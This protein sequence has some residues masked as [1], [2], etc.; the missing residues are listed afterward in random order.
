MSSTSGCIPR[1]TLIFVVAAWITLTITM[2][3]IASMNF[4][5]LDTENLRQADEVYRAIPEENEQR[6]MAVRYAASELNRF[7][8]TAYNWIQ[9]ALAG[10]TVLLVRFVPGAKKTSIV[11]LVCFATAIV[12][13]YPL[14]PMIVELGREI[15]FVPREPETAERTR[16]GKLHLLNVSLELT[17]LALLGGV[18]VALIRGS[19]SVD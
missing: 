8:F 2:A 1:A 19:K 11:L 3:F 9:L 4:K 15:D 14:L 12:L 17:K 10:L 18:A 16:F 13:L 7:Y 6:W 5:V